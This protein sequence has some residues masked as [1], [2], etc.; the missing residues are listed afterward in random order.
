MGADK[1]SVS[2]DPGLSRAIEEAARGEGESVSQWLAGAAEIRLRV[3]EGLKGVAA[4][5]AENGP[6]TAD[7]LAEADALLDE[8]LNH[9]APDMTSTKTSNP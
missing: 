6:L 8:L 5:E 3:R 4:W 2:F 9:W 1:R 7:E